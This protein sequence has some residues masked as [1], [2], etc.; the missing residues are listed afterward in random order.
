MELFKHTL[1]I[2]LDHR[3]DR[4]EHATAEFEKM[5]IVAERVKAIQPKNGAIGCTMSHIKCLELAKQRDYEQVFICEDDITFLN[6]ALFAQNLA[7]FVGN[8]DLRWDVIIIGGNNVPPYQQLHPYCARVFS[9]QT[10]TGYVVRREYYDTLITNFKDGLRKLIQQP[11]NGREFAIDI[12]WKRLQLE[13]FWY[14]IT[15]PT[16]SQYENYSDIEKRV[17][18]YEGLLL[19]MEKKWYVDQQ[20]RLGKM[21]R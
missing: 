8:E 17:T 10:T 1:F 2:N 6:P 18:Q 4:L 7:Q 19:D 14:M 12:Y 13:D 9:C 20:K 16:V 3:T 15:P 5:G 11:S 21:P